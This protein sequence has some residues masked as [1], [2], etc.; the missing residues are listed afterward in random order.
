MTTA[1]VGRQGPHGLGKDSCHSLLLTCVMAEGNCVDVP[2]MGSHR[3]AH[4]V[5]KAV[6]HATGY[7]MVQEG[8]NGSREI[9]EQG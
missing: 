3:A 9:R 5:L 4:V 1:P 8:V 7:F 2:D 6:P